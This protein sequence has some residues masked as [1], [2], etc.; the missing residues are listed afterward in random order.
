MSKV[1]ILEGDLIFIDKMMPEW[2]WMCIY[3]GKMGI[4][5]KVR[6]FHYSDNY[7]LHVY[8]FDL[9]EVFYFSDEHV[10]VFG[11]Q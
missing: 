3:E 11:F 1:P 7:M 4:V 9:Q 8:L 6:K 10:N 2:H 5:M